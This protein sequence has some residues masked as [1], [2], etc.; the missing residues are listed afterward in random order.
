MLIM[1]H[2]TQSMNESRKRSWFSL[3]NAHYETQPT[4][5]IHLEH[6]IEKY[7]QPMRNA[8]KKTQHDWCSIIKHI[9]KMQPCWKTGNDLKL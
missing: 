1:K 9:W 8:R 3:L 6:T 7:N 4:I 5:D 2:K